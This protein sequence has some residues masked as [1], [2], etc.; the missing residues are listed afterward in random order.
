MLQL[1]QNRATRLPSNTSYSELITPVLHFAP[2]PCPMQSSMQGLCPG[3][4]IPPE[5]RTSLHERHLSHCSHH[6][7]SATTPGSRDTANKQG[8]MCECKRQNFYETQTQIVQ[9][10]SQNDHGPCCFENYGEHTI[11]AW[12]LLNNSNKPMNEHTDTHAHPHTTI[13]HTQN[14]QITCPSYSQFLTAGKEPHDSIPG[15]AV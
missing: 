4:Q 1:V 3:I 7:T 15:S 8:V 14:T 12:L 6:L 5:D 2:T 11:W 10:T 13:I 9:L